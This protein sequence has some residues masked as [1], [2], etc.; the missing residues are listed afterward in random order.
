MKLDEHCAQATLYY[1]IQAL[2]RLLKGPGKKCI[3]KM[4]SVFFSKSM[5]DT[6]S[7]DPLNSGSMCCNFT[8]STSQ[9]SRWVN[10][11]T[12]SSRQILGPTTLAAPLA[13]LKAKCFSGQA[14][15]IPHLYLG[16]FV[17]LE[18]KDFFKEENV[19][20]LYNQFTSNLK[21]PGNYVNHQ[22]LHIIKHT[23]GFF[24]P[25]GVSESLKTKQKALRDQG[26]N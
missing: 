12:L 22:D 25:L 6:F 7:K 18:K 24:L 15:E 17:A 19:N 21:P 14:F 5:P 13:I 1:E 20:R 3:M 26:S 8:A 16:G 9:T 10:T 4:K 2:F 11:H 23:L